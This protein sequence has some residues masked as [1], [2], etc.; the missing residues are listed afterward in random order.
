[1]LPVWRWEWEG[2]V[3][4]AVVERVQVVRKTEVVCVLRFRGDDDGVL[5]FRERWEGVSICC[6]LLKR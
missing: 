2:A 5:E 3:A 6:L 1:L 4:M